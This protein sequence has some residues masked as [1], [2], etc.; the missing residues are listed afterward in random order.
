MSDPGSI[1]RWISALRE[2]DSSAASD[3]WRR[4]YERLVVLAR[5][6]LNEDA[7]RMADEE[8]V[9]V[10]AFDSFCRGIQLGR[11][12]VLNDRDDL[13]QVLVMLTARKAIN[14][15]KHAQRQKRGDGH[16]RGDSA[17]LSPENEQDG[18]NQVVGSEPTPEFAGQVKEEFQRLLDALGD[19]SL[20]QVAIAKMEGYENAEIAQQLGVQP[21]T[22]QRK[23]NVIR[24]IWSDSAI[25]PE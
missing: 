1:T 4:Y 8:D 2:G 17:F 11:F 21:R 14:Q 9:V 3:L 5:Q 10:D 16:V 13:W 18:I 23:L 7:R 20:R 12:P 22:I 24:V 15:R 19:E 25:L 6:K